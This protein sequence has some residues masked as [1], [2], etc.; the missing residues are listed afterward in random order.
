[1]MATADRVVVTLNEISGSARVEIA[2]GGAER[3]LAYRVVRRA[4]G[5]G[6]VVRDP[7][8]AAIDGVPTLERGV[9]I[10][11]GLAENVSEWAIG[12]LDC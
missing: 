3:P 5:L 6:Y 9:E 10:A 2:V 7:F 12:G 1:M 4:D 11:R 8:G